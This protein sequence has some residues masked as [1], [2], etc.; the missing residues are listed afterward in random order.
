M[1]TRHD[2]DEPCGLSGH[3]GSLPLHV[4][5]TRHQRL[6]RRRAADMLV[7]VQPRN[8]PVV[9]GPVVAVHGDLLDRV[10]A[11][12]RPRRRVMAG[13][14][15]HPHPA[16]LVRRSPR[17]CATVMRLERLGLDVEQ[18]VPVGAGAGAAA[19][20][21][22]AEAIVQ[23]RAPPGC[24]AALAGRTRRSA[25]ARSVLLGQDV[26]HARDAV[27]PLEHRRAR[28]RARARAMRCTPIA[29]LSCTASAARMAAG[30][31]ACRRPRA[32]SMSS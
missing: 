29:S 27:Q 4:E 9:G 1:S 7:V 14:K 24:S 17:R 25:A 11:R 15:R 30:S 22:D 23:Q 26:D 13:M 28:S 10:A 32:T 3:R 2:D 16:R 5:P 19:A 6:D 8:V 31:R 20:G 12:R 18:V 21:L